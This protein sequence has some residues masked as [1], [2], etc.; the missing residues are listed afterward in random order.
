MSSSMFS[1]I[2]KLTSS[3]DYPRWAQTVTAYLG[4][5]KALKVIKKSPV[6]LN[7]AGSNQDEVDAWEE[8]EGIARGVIILS[9]HPTIAEAVDM[10]M[11]VKE[12]WDDL[13][14]KYGKPGPSGIYLEFRKILATDIPANAD[15]SLAL[16]SLRT[17]F[18]KMKTLSCEIPH[19]IQVLVYMS[20]IVGYS[21]DFIIQGIHATDDLDKV[22][23]EDIE[24]MLRLN[25]EQKA[26]KK[27]PPQANKLS[28]VKRAPGEQ[29]FSGQQENQEDPQKKRGRRAG[30]R[31]QAAKSAEAAPPADEEHAQLA[32]PVIMPP[33]FAP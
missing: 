33:L 3:S 21:N 29:Q 25:W 20:K 32:C 7:A 30:K 1:E 24:K 12:V 18:T 11:S 15:P 27:G 10:T 8:V 6:T 2:P 9:L 17:G 16:E 14:K 4:V 23:L 19:K 13:A 22:V 31:K 28:A 26:S 5:Q